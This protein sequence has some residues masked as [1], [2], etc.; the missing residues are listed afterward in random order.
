MHAGTSQVTQLPRRRGEVET[1]TSCQTAM[2]RPRPQAVRARC[3]ALALS[4]LG[5]AKSMRALGPGATVGVLGTG[6]PRLACLRPAA[7]LK[8]GRSVAH[9]HQHKAQ[10]PRE[11]PSL[12]RQ[13]TRRFLKH[14]LLRLAREEA[15]RSRWGTSRSAHDASHDDQ[16][17]QAGASPCSVLP[18]LF[19]A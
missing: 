10:D 4:P 7:W 3:F 6:V 15:E 13:T 8:W 1:P 11:G 12:A 18:F 9:L 5:T 17:C 14:G 16:G 2:R 19:G